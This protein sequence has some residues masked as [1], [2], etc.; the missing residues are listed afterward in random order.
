MGG[1][2]KAK[3]SLHRPQVAAAVAAASVVKG[4]GHTK[5]ATWQS[6]AWPKLQ[7]PGV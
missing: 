5:M 6:V 4:D 7:R 2:G 3:R 1:K